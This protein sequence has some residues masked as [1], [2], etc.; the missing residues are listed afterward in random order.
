MK[1]RKKG[2][3]TTEAVAIL[4]RRHV[5]GKPEMEASLEEDR[6]NAEVARLVRDLRIQAGLT[7]KELADRAG[8]TPS[9]ISRLE[10]MNYGGHSLSMLRRIA[11]AVDQ[12]VQIRFI[13]AELAGPLRVASRHG[14]Q[15]LPD[16]PVPARE[17]S[18]PVDLPRPGQAV[19]CEVRDAL[20]RLPDPYVPE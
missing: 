10:D 16:P 15:R 6:G 2:K 20:H 19:R 7:Q 18:A 5:E 14:G 4:H 1:N 13:P 8:T 12:Q 3:T 17:I 9:V 11:A